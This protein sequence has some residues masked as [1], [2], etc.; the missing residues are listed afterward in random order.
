M[1]KRQARSETIKFSLAEVQCF[2]SDLDEAKRFYGEILGFE[3]KSESD[4]WLVFDI[5]GMDFVVISGGEPV[6]RNRPYG[7]ECATVLCLF[8]ENIE[9][10]TSIL[11][12]R[13]V[14]FLSEIQTVQ[15]G[16]FV[17]F[18]D[19]DGNLLELIQK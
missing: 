17:P 1:K 10:D 5:Q 16:K 19:P 4:R 3:L 2:V 9:R 11:K 6:D 8:S 15:E 7:S 13:G 12:S 18:E 14:R